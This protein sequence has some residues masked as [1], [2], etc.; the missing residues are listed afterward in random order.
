MK[1]NISIFL[2]LALF[3]SCLLM[4]SCGSNTISGDST[5]FRNADE[6]FSIQ[7]PASDDKS[8]VINEDTSGDVLDISNKDDTVNLQIE[9]LSK[10][11]A[12]YIASD[13]DS[14]EDYAI[15]NTLSD[16]YSDMDVKDIEIQTPDFITN[17]ISKSYTLKDGSSTVKGVFLLMESE[18]CYYTYLIMAID[19]AYDANED[20]LMDSI[21]SLKELSEVPASSENETQ[22]Q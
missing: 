3:I 14:Y 15:T 16:M 12:Q 8:W 11:Q 7:L 10:S 13:L 2:S 18:K 4:S 9:C 19:E 1:K 5:E 6:S 21:T 17:S 20:K 22:E